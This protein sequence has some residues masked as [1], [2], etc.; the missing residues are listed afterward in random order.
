MRDLLTVASVLG[1]L[2]V[3]LR[4]GRALVRALGRS[5]EHVAAGHTLDARAQR[6]DLTGM[7]EAGQ[8]RK[9]VARKRT[10][11]VATSAFWAALLIAPAYTSITRLVYAAYA[12]LW[13]VDIVARRV[14]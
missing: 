10:R 3:L 1:F 13:V 9:A 12:V 5:A 2:A 7:A 8:W 4:L 6:G 11:A 14:G